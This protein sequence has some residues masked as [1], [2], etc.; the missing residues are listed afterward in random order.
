MAASS[1]NSIWGVKFGVLT[2]ATNLT[3]EDELWSMRVDGATVATARI[4]I[5]QVEWRAPQDLA[6]FVEGVE[7]RIPDAITQH[8]DKPV[9]L[10]S[11]IGA[12]HQG[13]LRGVREREVMI[14][15]SFAPHASETV[16]AVEAAREQGARVIA[17]TDSRMSPLAAHA[18]HS[19]IVHESSTFGFR[20]LTN[21]MALAQ[22]LFI[23]LAYRLELSYAPTVPRATEETAL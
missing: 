12:M 14:A 3:V 1:G 5:D 13:Q 20:A 21:A 18:A 4:V 22:G 19:F 23:A 17:I 2:P 10:V 11:F 7:K 8:T 9:Q 15:V 6:T 16:A